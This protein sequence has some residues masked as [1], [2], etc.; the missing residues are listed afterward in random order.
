MAY[1]SDGE[2]QKKI[3]ALGEVLFAALRF[4]NAV[5][6]AQCRYVATDA[7]VMEQD[8]KLEKALETLRRQ[9]DRHFTADGRFTACRADSRHATKLSAVLP[10]LAASGMNAATIRATKLLRGL[11]VDDLPQDESGARSGDLPRETIMASA[12]GMGAAG[13]D[14]LLLTH[15]IPLSD[16]LAFETRQRAQWRAEWDAAPANQADNA[17]DITAEMQRKHFGSPATEPVSV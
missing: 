10:G 12:I 9:L 8:S 17:S 5:E 11:P 2:K 13:R 16:F 1:E 6:A 14:L 7:L 4:T 15:R 3:D